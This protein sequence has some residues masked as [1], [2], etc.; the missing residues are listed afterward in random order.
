MPFSSSKDNAVATTTKPKQFA[1]SRFVEV[2]DDNHDDLTTHKKYRL[3]AAAAVFNSQKEI[4]VGERSTIAGA[5]QCPQGGV[6]AAWEENGHPEETVV[7]AA[8]R[9]LY[10][11]MGLVLGQHVVLLSPDK[12]DLSH[13]IRYETS[14]TSNWLTRAGFS[15]Q[16]LQWV[17]FR[18]M[19]GRGDAHPSVMC[20]VSGQKGESPEFS[21]VAWRPLSQ[22]LDEMWPAKRGPYEALQQL[23]FETGVDKAWYDRCQSFASE[24]TGIWSRD[25]RQSQHLVPALVARGMD[26]AEAQATAEAPYRQEWIPKQDAEHETD[27]HNPSTMSLPSWT[28]V[29][30]ADDGTTPRRTLH[31]PWGEWDETYHGASTLFGAASESK[32]ALLKRRTF[33]APTV[34][35]DNSAEIVVAHVTV[36]QTPNGD[37]EEARR[38]RLGDNQLIL[39]RTYWPKDTTTPT[40]TEGVVSLE[41]FRRDDK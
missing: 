11:E 34:I 3:C 24:L 25:A 12:E 14:G 4:L 10:E 39:Q 38:Y 19:D 27:N 7:Q 40:S 13:G 2:N 20:D 23:L 17:L 1:P 22:V 36:S 30:F 8:T 32:P 41:V 18:C 16:Q 26:E 37:T 33:Y 28:V 29:T 15:G 31:Y 35:G 6:D 5:W 9:E 21:Q